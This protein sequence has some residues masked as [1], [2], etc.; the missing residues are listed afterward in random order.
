MKFFKVRKSNE[1]IHNDITFKVFYINDDM[2]KTEYKSFVDAKKAEQCAYKLFNKFKHQEPVWVER[3]K[4]NYDDGY[5]LLDLDPDTYDRKPIYKSYKSGYTNGKKDYSVG[6]VFDVDDLESS[7]RYSKEWKEG[8]WQGVADAQEKEFMKQSSEQIHKVNFKAQNAAECAKQLLKDFDLYNH[9]SSEVSLGDMIETKDGNKFVVQDVMDFITKYEKEFYKQSSIKKV[10]S[11]KY[12]YMLLDRLIQDAKYFIVHPNLKH[13]WARTLDEHIAKMIEQ[14]AKLDPK[15]EWTSE[16][17]INDLGKQMKESYK[18]HWNEVHPDNKI[19]AAIQQPHHNSNHWWLLKDREI[20][21]KNGEAFKRAVEDVLNDQRSFDLL[22]RK[23]V[24]REDGELFKKVIDYAIKEG[25]SYDLLWQK[26]V[27]RQDKELFDKVVKQAIKDHWSIA[28]IKD[29]I[30]TEEELELYK[31]KDNKIEAAI[32]QP[33]KPKPTTVLPQ[34]MEWSWDPNAQ[35]WVAVLKDNT[36][37]TPPLYDPNNQNLVNQNTTSYM[38]NVKSSK[39]HNYEDDLTPEGK[40]A[41]DFVC[42]LLGKKL[43][44]GYD[45]MYHIYDQVIIPDIKIAEK[46]NNDSRFANGE[47]WIASASGKWGTGNSYRIGF[48][49]IKDDKINASNKQ[50][51]CLSEFLDGPQ[52]SKEIKIEAGLIKDGL[53]K[54]AGF[55]FNKGTKYEITEKGL[56]VLRN[57]SEAEHNEA[58]NEREKLAYLFGFNTDEISTLDTTGKTIKSEGA[59]KLNV[60]SLINKLY[61]EIKKSRNHWEGIDPLE[62]T[63]IDAKDVDGGTEIQVRDELSYEG[64]MKLAELLNKTIKEVDPQAYFEPLEPGIMIAFISNGNNKNASK[65]F[66]KKFT[67]YE[68][69]GTE[70]GE[71]EAENELDAKVKFGIEHPEYA[72]SQSIKVKYNIYKDDSLYKDKSKKTDSG[73]YIPYFKKVDDI[74]MKM[75]NNRFSSVLDELDDALQY[76]YG[77]DIETIRNWIKNNELSDYK[78]KKAVLWYWSSDGAYSFD[79]HMNAYK[80]LL[81]MYGVNDDTVKKVNSQYEQTT[82]QHLDYPNP[83]ETPH[84]DVII[85]N[86]DGWVNTASFEDDIRK[87][88]MKPHQPIENSDRDLNLLEEQILQLVNDDKK[89]EVHKLFDQLQFSD[90]QASVD[91]KFA[92]LHEILGNY[93]KQD[94]IQDIIQ[95]GEDLL[96]T[97]SPATSF[98]LKEQIESLGY[99]CEETDESETGDIYTLPTF[100]LRIKMK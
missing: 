40:E 52:Y 4:G 51:S 100:V 53:V 50:A 47:N 16:E 3:Y 63:Y 10:S 64:M 84:T 61:N 71:V 81:E 99:E 74:V 23:I 54:Y 27:T 86:H 25:Y 92:K 20:T 46:I 96:V 89:D 80:G 5:T 43:D 37:V 68:A 14:Y 56:K 19:E 31:N 90:K 32:E 73:E 95:D 76:M 13:L 38:S 85:E 67:I 87:Q 45:P 11:D 59:K 55:D 58:L 35:D 66:T 48:S 29:K 44:L 8:Y 60:K 78:L 9:F 42:N 72:D 22:D 34:N 65:K 33:N 30:I 79:D 75:F 2:E 36:N 97:C 21:R 41:Y 98:E 1:Q 12:E 70:L 7:W 6:K 94:K 91:P 17:E 82:E 24:T 39:Y 88:F 26:F 69:D 49:S 77:T 62:Y 15:P 28:L 93:R 57:A 18:N 83:S